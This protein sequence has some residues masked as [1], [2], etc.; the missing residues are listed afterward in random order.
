M[1]RADQSSARPIYQRQ[2]V[3]AAH[4]VA[5][6]HASDADDAEVHVHFPEGIVD[7]ER[8]VAVVVAQRGIHVHLEIPH[9]VL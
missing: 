6:A 9:R 3:V 4:L 7:L 8:K 2:G 5:Y 1:R